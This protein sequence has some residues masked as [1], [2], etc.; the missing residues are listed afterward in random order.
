M[1]RRKAWATTALVAAVSGLTTTAV[2]HAQLSADGAPTAAAFEAPLGVDLSRARSVETAAGSVR[3]AP[4]ADGSVCLGARDAKGSIWT[5][6]PADAAAR[7]GVL[8]TSRS[9]ADLSLLAAYAVL[10]DGAH[11]ATLSG[12]SGERAVEVVD[13][14][15]AST[16]ADDTTLSFVD[17]AGVQHTRALP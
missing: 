10:P 14:V 1:R 13:D 16:R 6:A 8:L 12:P 15:V 9:Q 11:D 7:D 4:G 3:V 2:V 5:C 17:A